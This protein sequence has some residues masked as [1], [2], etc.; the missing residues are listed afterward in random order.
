[1]Y[2]R[3]RW[4]MPTRPESIIL[5][6]VFILKRGRG[7]ETQPTHCHST[8]HLQ[9]IFDCRIERAYGS[10]CRLT[11]VS[12]NRM[13]PTYQTASRRSSPTKTTFVPR[14]VALPCSSSRRIRRDGVLSTV[15]MKR[16][17]ESS[18]K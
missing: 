2:W 14:M 18:S 10:P 9:L 13:S 4:L 12:Q 6:L 7:G 3:L 5:S 15:V 8:A 17:D 11:R 1:M 16:R